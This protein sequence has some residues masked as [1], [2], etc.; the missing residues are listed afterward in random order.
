MIAMIINTSLPPQHQYI[1]ILTDEN[2]SS[3]TVLQLQFDSS[4]VNITV[5]NGTAYCLSMFSKLSLTGVL[6]NI[7]IMSN[8][9]TGQSE[10]IAIL[11]VLQTNTSGVGNIS[12]LVYLHLTMVCIM[13]KT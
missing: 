7:Y 4:S 2:Q 5:D 13:F 1:G 3:S 9:T 10:G 8:V 11:H 6:I 12:I